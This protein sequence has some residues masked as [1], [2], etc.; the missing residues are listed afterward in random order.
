MHAESIL[1]FLAG[2]ALMFKGAEWVTDSA[3]HLAEKLHTSSVAVGLILVSLVLSLPE[4]F[5]A[6]LSILKDH[7]QIGLGTILCSVIVNIGFVAGVCS[8]IRPLKLSRVILLRDTIFMIVAT[9][10]VA[11][12]ALED[13]RLSQVEGLVF[14]LLFVPYLVNV[15]QQEHQ[16]GKKK[17]KAEGKRIV[18]TLQ[19]VGNLPFMP[20]RIR[21]GWGIFLWGAAVLLVGAQFFTDGLIHFAEAFS[22][23]DLA[24]GIT[25]GALGPSLPNFAA[26][27]SATRRGLEELA[28]SE[29]IGSNIFTLLV[30]V[31]LFALFSPIVLEASSR[32]VTVPALL[33]ITFLFMG[34][35]IK[36]SITR[37][38]GAVLFVAYVAAVAAEVLYHA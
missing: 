4:I 12:L 20:F 26:A 33:L 2:V 31:G 11:V 38:E 27:L 36:G 30:S 7:P 37:K 21:D 28:I 34:F 13:S 17:A 23:S 3:S 24:V 5:V 14:I 22:I 35:T 8:M 18:H 16:M 32:A 19:L 1:L 25:L 6:A 9:I 15:Y 10:I 29:T